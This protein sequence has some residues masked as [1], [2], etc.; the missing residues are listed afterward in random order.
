MRSG[1]WIDTRT[2][3]QIVGEVAY[4]ERVGQSQPG[5]LVSIQDILINPDFPYNPADYKKPRKITHDRDQLI[6]YGTWILSH[7]EGTDH[8]GRVTREHIARLGAFAVGPG[9]YGVKSQFDGDLWRFQE[10]IGS[11]AKRTLETYHEWTHYRLIEFAHALSKRLRRKPTE[12]DY[13]RACEDLDAPSFYVLR[14]TIGGIA[15]INELIGYPNIQDWNEED[16]VNWGVKVMQANNGARPTARIM[17]VLSQR[18]RGPSPSIVYQKFKISYFQERVWERYGQVVEEDQV[19]TAERLSLYD[20]TAV[21]TDISD[22]K[23]IA[24]IGKHELAR[25]LVRN[26]PNS[27]Y[28]FLS[29]QPVNEFVKLIQR[30]TDLSLGHIELKAV[31]LGVYDDIWPPNTSWMRYLAVSEKELPFKRKGNKKHMFT[32]PVHSDEHTTD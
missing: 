32:L 7:L 3:D 22:Q 10:A 13:E 24:W 2:G 21:S 31:S 9:V 8:E 18:K 14:Q 28:D 11:G 30:D 25:A 1:Y 5:D 26:K 4:D 23:K 12:V 15:K 19:R 6:A 27:Y 16:Y 20:E 29:R 17:N